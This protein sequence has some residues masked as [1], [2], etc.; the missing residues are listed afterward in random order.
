MN[1]GNREDRKA[2]ALA[3]GGGHYAP[4]VVARG[5]GALADAVIDSARE[6]GVFIHESPE[7]INLLMGVDLDRHIPPEL[8]RA[9]AELL[10]WVYWL[11][12]RVPPGWQEGD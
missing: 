10:A 1:R 7:L 9:V 6:A 2:V 3:Y 8:Y 11:E 12:N 4:K 5:V